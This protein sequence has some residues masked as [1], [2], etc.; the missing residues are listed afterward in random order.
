M[1]RGKTTI[2]PDVLTTIARMTTLSIDGVSRLADDIPNVS[3]L[4]R[5]RVN[6]GVE[7]EIKEDAVF[8]NLYV[9]LEN[10]VNFR[11]VSRNIQQQ[12][13]RAI[14]EMVGMQVGRINIHIVDIDYLE[15]AE[16]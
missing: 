3:R 5:H 14:A 12:V 1:I 6:N 7:I 4:F 16:V 11:D 8:A 9:I 10:D 15:V 2:A 13:S